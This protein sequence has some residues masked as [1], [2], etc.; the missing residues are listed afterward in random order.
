MPDATH[1]LLVNAALVFGALVLLWLLSLRLRDA[2]IIDLFWGMGFVIV[3]WSTWL[4]MAPAARPLPV[5]PALATL[6]GVRL[7][8][9]LAARNLGHGEDK[10]YAAMRAARPTTFGWWSLVFVFLFQGVL[11]QIIALP[12]VFGQLVPRGPFGVLDVVGLLVFAFGF[13]YEAIADAQ[14]ARWKRDPSN[15][16]KVMAEGL[17]KH[18]R[19]PNYFGE[20]TL[21]WGIWLVAASAPLDPIGARWTVVGPLL[22]TFLLLRVSGV[23]L[24]EKS[25]VHRRPEYADYIRRTNAFIPGPRRP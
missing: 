3:A 7:S 5:L 18:T 21:W 8:G 10:R 14:L 22:I 12:L 9:Y 20:A 1:V 19:H 17:W 13:L 15:A 11:C 23:S 24:L 25:I 6:W 4:Q 16:G 2:S